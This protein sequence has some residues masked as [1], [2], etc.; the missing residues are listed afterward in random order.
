MHL[1]LLQFWQATEAFVLIRETA[2]HL[3]HPL[4]E[5]GVDDT[6]SSAGLAGGACYLRTK[7]ICN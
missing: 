5:D 2:K 4:T 3:N 7:M 1:Q 6:K